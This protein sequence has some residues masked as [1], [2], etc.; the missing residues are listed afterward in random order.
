M[1]RSNALKPQKSIHH[2]VAMATGETFSIFL[3]MACVNILAYVYNLPQ[4][5]IG[6]KKGFSVSYL[7]K[8]RQIEAKSIVLSIE[9]K[10]IT[11]EITRK[12]CFK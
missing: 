7:L 12:T 4:D 3:C 6:G 8:L 10:L 5:Q 2:Y 1:L 11:Q 9:C